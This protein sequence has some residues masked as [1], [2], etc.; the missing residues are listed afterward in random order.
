MTKVG[1]GGRER[2]REGGREGKKEERVVRTLFY[3]VSFFFRRRHLILPHKLPFSNSCFLPPSL[4]PSLP[5]PAVE[6]YTQAADFFNSENN[7]SSANDALQ[8]TAF[9]LT[10]SRGAADP[11]LDNYA[12]AAKIFEEVRWEAGREG[13]REICICSPFLH[14]SLVLADGRRSFGQPSVAVQRQGPLYE[15][16]AL[17]YGDGG[18]GRE[19]GRAGGIRRRREARR[20]GRKV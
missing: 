19:G 6:N 11:S 3:G 2:G 12:R 1:E 8:K 15:R 7:K 20:Q 16:L 10:T 17:L 14:P 18:R 13:G 4:P 9:L 5:P